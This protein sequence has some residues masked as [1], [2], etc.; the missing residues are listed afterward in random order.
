MKVGFVCGEVVSGEAPVERLGDLAP[1]VLEG[2]E[3]VGELAEVGEVVR[4]EQGC[5]SG[6]GA[7]RSILR[8]GGR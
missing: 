6:P 3:G 1:V 8:R 4:L 2:V 5:A 7:A